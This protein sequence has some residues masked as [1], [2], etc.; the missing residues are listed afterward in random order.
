VALERVR[1]EIAGRSVVVFF[2]LFFLQFPYRKYEHNP[3]RYT[4]S[5][6]RKTWC[7]SIPTH[8]NNH[9]AINSI[10]TKKEIKHR[11]L[12]IWDGLKTSKPNK[13][14]RNKFLTR[15]LQMEKWSKNS[16]HKNEARYES[17]KSN[18]M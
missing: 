18:E 1:V 3:S 13:M 14:K 11:S 6:H 5:E 16:A 2:F 8:G 9:A 4:H 17:L 15:D 7:V 12:S 10:K